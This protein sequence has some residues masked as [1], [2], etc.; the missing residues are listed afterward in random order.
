MKTETEIRQMLYQEQSE[1]KLNETYM[2]AYATHGNIEKSEE[3][4]EQCLKIDHRIAILKEI[5]K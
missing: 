5:L 2:L 4:R 3:C 1:Y